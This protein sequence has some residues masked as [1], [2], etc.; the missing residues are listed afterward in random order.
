M[1][2]DTLSVAN[3]QAILISNQRTGDPFAAA[4][5]AATATATA[6]ATARYLLDSASASAH[7]LPP[8]M[9]ADLDC[10]FGAAMGTDI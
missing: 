1:G 7:S 4:A 3:R 8:P 9:I 2:S 6:T 10:C 5:A